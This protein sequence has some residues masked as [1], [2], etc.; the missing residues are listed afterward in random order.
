MESERAGTGSLLSSSCYI[1][2]G[3]QIAGGML[4]GRR[5]YKLTYWGSSN[6]S[7]FSVYALCNRAEPTDEA[8]A[9]S[10]K[11]WILL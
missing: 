11:T 9:L 2:R 6:S 4:Y 7:T 3:K 8:E 1:Q 5:C 10:L